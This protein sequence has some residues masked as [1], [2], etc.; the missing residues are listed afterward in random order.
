M[1]SNNAAVA[2]VT[3]VRPCSGWA[4]GEPRAC[5]SCVVARAMGPVLRAVTEVKTGTDWRPRRQI[6]RRHPESNWGSG[7]CRALPYH[8]AMSPNDTEF[9][10]TPGTYLPTLMTDR[11]ELH[12]FEL[13]RRHRLQLIQV[14]VVPTRVRLAGDVPI[15]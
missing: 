12:H 15:G 1:R 11:A 5:R 14:V 10:A 9:S 13:R 6:W 4:S 3:P 8:L 7:F 2:A